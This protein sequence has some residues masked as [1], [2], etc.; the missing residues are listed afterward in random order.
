MTPKL[1]VFAALTLLTLLLAC[2]NFGFS[3]KG[4]QYGGPY[5]PVLEQM[6]PK[7][8]VFED[9]RETNAVTETIILNVDLLKK[10]INEHARHSYG[11]KYQRYNYVLNENDEIIVAQWLGGSHIP[12]NR[13][14]FIDLCT[15]SSSK[16]DSDSDEKSRLI[17]KFRDVNGLDKDS[18]L[19]M[20]FIKRV[21]ID[22]ALRNDAIEKEGIRVKALIDDSALVNTAHDMVNFYAEEPLIKGTEVKLCQGR[23]ILDELTKHFMLAQGVN[24]SDDTKINNSGFTYKWRFAEVAYAGEIIVDVVGCQYTINNGSGTYTPDPKYLKSVADR[25]GKILGINAPVYQ[26][27]NGK[28]GKGPRKPS[29]NNGKLPS[30]WCPPELRR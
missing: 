10:S 19:L 27:D 5:L 24:D 22:E 6:V 25:F 13:D 23:K 3:S 14:T 9:F 8:A 20:A 30:D 15:K 26:I 11:K 1:M 4:D 18:E 21:N 28:L 2:N 17:E 12:K 29:V 16:S 7:I